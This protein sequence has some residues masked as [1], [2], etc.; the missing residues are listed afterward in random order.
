[1]IFGEKN[2]DGFNQQNLP[3]FGIDIKNWRKARL[4]VINKKVHI[5]LDGFLIYKTEYTQSVGSIMGIEVTSKASG[6]TDY[7]KLYN[8][9]KELVYEDDFGGEM[10]GK[11]E[12]ESPER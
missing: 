2:I 7:I 9:N 4:E 5:Y 6:E 11:K 12:Q 3:Q 8:S 10:S 1:M